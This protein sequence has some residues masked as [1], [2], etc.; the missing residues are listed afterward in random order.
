MTELIA[1]SLLFPNAFWQVL[2]CLLFFLFCF[3]CVGF[4]LQMEG[5][6]LFLSGA[7]ALDFRDRFW[8]RFFQFFWNYVLSWGEGVCWIADFR[9]ICCIFMLFWSKWE[10]WGLK[11]FLLNLLVFIS[12]Y[13]WFSGMFLTDFLLNFLNC[14]KFSTFLKNIRKSK[15][16]PMFFEFRKLGLKNFKFNFFIRVCF[17]QCS[18]FCFQY[19]VFLSKIVHLFNV[20]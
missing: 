17:K 20:F 18:I 6:L 2:F 8:T 14:F 12:F 13:L 16:T 4:L 1:S 9:G 3:W 10:H 5:W 11:K 7:C 15:R 19:F